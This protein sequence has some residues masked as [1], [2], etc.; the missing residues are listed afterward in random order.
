MV[1]V[2]HKHKLF[3]LVLGL[4]FSLD[5]FAF[6][7]CFFLQ[8][9]KFLL[10]AFLSFVY[11]DLHS[12]QVL[13]DSLNHELVLVLLHKFEIGG[14]FDLVHLRL[15]LLYV[16]LLPK[17]AVF[18]VVLFVLNE[19][20]L[21]LDNLEFPLFGLDLATGLVELLAEFA[22]GCAHLFDFFAAA[23]PRGNEVIW[24]EQGVLGLVV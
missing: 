14:F 17:Q 13:G 21:L 23:L 3:Q 1:V 18:D 15:G 5:C 7:F 12:D 19:L 16:V 11:V 20:K 9:L 8:D 6:L 22:H 4:K 10:I 24:L 2:D